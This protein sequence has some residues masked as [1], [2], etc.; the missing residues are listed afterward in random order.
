MPNSLLSLSWWARVAAQSASSCSNSGCHGWS[1]A[2]DWGFGLRT[3]FCA[4][5]VSWTCVHLRSEKRFRP[6]EWLRRVATDG[7][8]A[9]VEANAV[10]SSEALTMDRSSLRADGLA[11]SLSRSGGINGV[12]SEGAINPLAAESRFD[13]LSSCG[14]AQMRK[15]RAPDAA[16]RLGVDLVPLTDHSTCDFTEPT[17][18]P[19]HPLAPR[20]RLHTS[21]LFTMAGYVLSPAAGPAR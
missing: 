11:R 2:G 17:H 13:A 4:S 5:R 9:V 15:L 10:G 18:P 16:R 19:T 7:Q 8:P 1:G 12:A 21:P 3:R 6:L 14:C 20:H